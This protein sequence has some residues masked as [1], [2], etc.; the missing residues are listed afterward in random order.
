MQFKAPFGIYRKDNKN[1]L[2][3]LQKCSLSHWLQKILASSGKCFCIALFCVDRI[4]RTTFISWKLN[5]ADFGLNCQLSK[6]KV[7]TQLLINLKTWS[8]KFWGQ[9][10]LLPLAIEEGWYYFP[11]TF[12]SGVLNL[13]HLECIKTERGLKYGVVSNLAII[14]EF[15]CAKRF[16][17]FTFKV[18]YC[19]FSMF[20]MMVMK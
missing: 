3:A 13:F 4:L 8:A 6:W 14:Y 19:L 12:P 10:F 17:F 11:V 2:M 7:Y 20:L 5:F 18:Y 15:F 1:N 16:Y 9:E